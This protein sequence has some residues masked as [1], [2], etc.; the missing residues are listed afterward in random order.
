MKYLVTG[1]SGFIGKRLIN[2]IAERPDTTIYFLIRPSSADRVAGLLQFWQDRRARLVP[3]HG[4][5]LQP[6]LG[7]SAVEMQQLQGV[8]HVVHL[9]AI[10]DLE[11]DPGLEIRTNVEGT[12]NAVALAGRIG[13]G[14]FHHM[15]SIAAAGL[16]PGIFR[17]DMFAEAEQ[18]DHPY[19]R[20]KHEAEKVVRA[21]CT[22]PWRIYRPGLV[23]GD[24]RTG[25]AEKID[26]PY[27]FFKPIQRLRRLLPA[28][29]PGV[30]V[31]GGT[32]NIVPVDFVVAALDHL[33][34]LD[35]LDGKCFHLTDPKPH[36]V[37]DILAIFARAAHAPEPTVRFNPALLG[38]L[39]AGLLTGML[40]VGPVRRIR[41]ALM[42]DLGLPP[43]ILHFVNYP[44]RFDNR[45][46][47]RWLTPAGITVPP[48]ESYAWKLWDHWERHMDPDLHID[49]SLRGAVA[50][51]LVIVTGGAAGIG[52]A[53]SLKLAGAGARVL[54][55]DRDA[56]ALTATAA[57]AE[58]QG[59]SLLT[60]VADITDAEQCADLV[61][62]ILAEPGGP[63]IL[64]NNAGRSIRRPIEASYDRFHDFERMM[65]VNYFGCLRLTLGLLPAM[66]ARG[67][68][69][70]VNISSIGVL[71]NAPRF[72]AYVASKAALEAWTRCAA[73]E[74][75]DQGVEFTTIN[76]PLVRT[77]MIAPTAV[78]KDAPT[79][80]PE[81]A[82][83]LVVEAIVKRP[84][85]LATR[86][87]LFGEVLNA[88]SPHTAQIITNTIFRLFPDGSAEQP[89]GG[90]TEPT[91]D[92]VA[93]SQMMRGLHF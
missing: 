7:I 62:R 66:A 31:E 39:P 20:S 5:L 40:S 53:T 75:L 57:E 88:L 14:R 76:M 54:I 15:S 10:Y 78:Y 81:E 49:R 35:S 36:R 24:S 21:E 2:K 89:K 18:L 59:L 1:G 65:A 93:I 72:S 69:H 87:G 32:I 41:Q 29:A 68:G 6:D 71:T 22:V 55:A 47:E 86:L 45:E 42:K 46:A 73:A 26:G 74:L 33:A 60:Q 16:Y 19:F 8:D 27:Y 92:Q 56:D 63:D 4:D 83:G 13:A 11:A 64:I 34:H 44:T 67:R 52:K 25:E 48:L 17:E 30:G 77:A 12:R 9:A 61:R 3:I 43:D 50:G 38:R 70:V 80:T 84:V 51:R 90:Q 28:W 79:L 37:G 85:R 58:A 23:V 91:A 82:A